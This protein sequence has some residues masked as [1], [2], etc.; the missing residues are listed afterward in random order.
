MVDGLKFAVTVQI[1]ATPKNFFKTK[2]FL[3]L[4]GILSGCSVQTESPSS[5]AIGFAQP[6]EVEPLTFK[7]SKLEYEIDELYMVVSAVEVHLCTT[8]V[9]SMSLIPS[10]YAHVS[11]SATRLGTPV[12]V[13]LH[14][15]KFSPTII[16]EISPPVGRY[17][18]GYV[19]VAP[20]DDDVMNLTDLGTE[21]IVGKSV[22]IKGRFRDEASVEWAEFE[23]AFDFR[24]PFEFD[25]INPKTGEDTLEVVGGSSNQITID[26]PWPKNDAFLNPE[27]SQ[28][29]LEIVS[30]VTETMKMR[31]YK[32]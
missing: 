4:L 29:A 27:D 22:F 14:T 13:P 10:A 26:L 28:F 2:T 7:I 19:I 6:E 30:R 16:G 8:P 3:F 9:V 17:C 1:K 20:A 21:K 32:K 11:D 31:S 23:R 15:R 12:V 24:G 18:L 5:V 25:L